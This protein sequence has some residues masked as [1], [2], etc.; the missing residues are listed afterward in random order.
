MEFY[1]AFPLFPVVTGL[2]D[3]DA[4][5]DRFSL[6]GPCEPFHSVFPPGPSP[7]DLPLQGLS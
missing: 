3:P 2:A 5:S 6:K 4:V 1:N 7:W